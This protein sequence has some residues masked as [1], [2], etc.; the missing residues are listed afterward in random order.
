MCRN[1]YYYDDDDDPVRS[2]R[3]RDDDWVKR[4][5]NSRFTNVSDRFPICGYKRTYC[6][7]SKKKTTNSYSRV[8]RPRFVGCFKHETKKEF[9]VPNRSESTVNKSRILLYV[10]VFFRTSYRKRICNDDEIINSW[11][12]KTD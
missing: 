9:D 8:C 4:F 10:I 12:R 1:K 5:P 3:F 7:S 11:P 6:V 2:V